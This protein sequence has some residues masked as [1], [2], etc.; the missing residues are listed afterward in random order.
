M[1]YESDPWG[2]EANQR[3]LNRVVILETDLSAQ[4]LLSRVLAIEKEL[5]RERLV[6]GYSSR[7]IDIDILYYSELQIAEPDL[8][9]PHPGIPDRRFV[10]VP[11]TEVAGSFVHPVLKKSN[12]SLLEQCGDKSNVRIYEV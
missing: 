12:A 1:V 2:F 7:K 9:I 6:K 5:G 3:F 4:P 11:L 8:V 10:L